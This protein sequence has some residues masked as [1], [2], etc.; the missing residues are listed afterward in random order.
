MQELG[1]PSSTWQPTCLRLPPSPP[2][3]ASDGFQHSKPYTCCIHRCSSGPTKHGC[4]SGH[5]THFSINQATQGS[6]A[7]V[8]ALTFLIL[9]YY[10]QQQ[11]CCAVR[12][13]TRGRSQWQRAA[14]NVVRRP[15]PLPLL[16]SGTQPQ[17]PEF[18]ATHHKITSLLKINA[19]A[20]LC[21]IAVNAGV[22]RCIG[23]HAVTEP[24]GLRITVTVRRQH[25][26]VRVS[27]YQCKDSPPWVC[28]SLYQCK[29]RP[30]LGLRIAV[31]VRRQHPWVCISLYQCGDSTPRPAYHCIS[32][33]TAPPGLRITVSVR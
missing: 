17:N 18:N 27:L 5:M 2:L 9:T 26:W 11:P 32:A 4:M 24:P 30:P 31:S 28:V 20:A 19:W 7:R 15:R 3:R 16:K 6:V 33:V 8:Q 21:C 14:V 13:A 1:S 10:T 29:D 25:P 22:G 23:I 12:A